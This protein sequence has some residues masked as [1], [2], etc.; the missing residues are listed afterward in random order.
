MNE[1]TSLQNPK[2]K[3]L[4]KLL[5]DRAY[6]YERQEFIAEGPRILDFVK[7][8]KE[9]YYTDEN[10]L[11]QIPGYKITPL[12]LNKI[13]GTETP[14]GV[15]AL[16][17]MDLRT[18]LPKQ[19]SY[20]YLDG[21]Q[22]PGNAG[23]II[24]TAAA[25]GLDGVIFGKGSVDPYS[26]K[27]VRSSMGA[28]FQIGIYQIKLDQLAGHLVLAADLAGEPVT[29]SLGQDFILIIGSEGKGLSPEIKQKA[30]KT[31]TIP[32]SQK[33]ESL[34]AAVSAGILLYIL[35]K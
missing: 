5:T 25:F 4:Q 7:N 24:R 22:D 11:S 2:V 20:V 3:H 9:I 28:I 33:V 30:T 34:N 31:L 8:V 13:S 35:K 27:V 18:I 15:V 16:C 23:T 12:V 32:V 10:P 17:N 1:L 29:K 19:G 14:Q 21:I 26:P 6:R